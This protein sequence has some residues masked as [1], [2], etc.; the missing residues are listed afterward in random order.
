MPIGMNSSRE[1]KQ[2]RRRRLPKRH[3][4]SEFPPPQTSSHLIQLAQFVKCWQ[5]FWSWILRLYQSPGNV[6]KKS[7]S[8]VHVLDEA[9]NQAL[10]RC[11]RAATAK[12]CT[13]KRGKVVNLLLFCLSRCRRCRRL[14]YLSSLIA[15]EQAYFCEL[16]ENFG[17]IA[18][19]YL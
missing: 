17:A 16:G 18:L 15:S 3:L 1:L 9:W 4:K 8:C 11:S 14:R 13:K 2:Q 6:K 10:S 12:K 5:I 19:C 7:L